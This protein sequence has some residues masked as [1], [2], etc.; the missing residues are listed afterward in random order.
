M[1]PLAGVMAPVIG[2]M[3]VL[4]GCNREAP[5]LDKA[6]TPVRV[7]TVAMYTPSGGERYSASML[8]DRQ[9]TLSFRIGGF[10]ESVYQLGNGRNVDIG[11]VIPQ[12]TVLARIRTQDYQLAVNQ[13]TSQ[14][15]Q[16]RQAQQTA[17]AQLAQAEASAA[18]AVLEYSVRS[19]SMG[20][21]VVIRSRSDWLL[22][23]AT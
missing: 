13:A 8:P 6:P 14:V 10:V 7:E 17:Q 20:Y 12:G 22:G 23:D 4:A 19:V 11:D 16:A 2:A 1:R 18:K 3:V 15:Q 21:D 9:V 5:K